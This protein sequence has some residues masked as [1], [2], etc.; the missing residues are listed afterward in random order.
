MSELPVT[1]FLVDDDP[2]V[3]ASLAWLLE[4]VKIATRTENSP[5]AF[6]QAIREVS[7][8]ACAVLDLRMSEMSGLELQ[9]RLTAEGLE[10]P[11]IFLTAHGDVPAAVNAMQAGAVDFLQKPFNP[12]VFLS[13]VN[14]MIRQ[15]RER[16]GEREEKARLARLLAKLS[17]READVLDALFDG[18]T[19]KEIGRLLEVSPKTVDVHRANI[20]RKLG[21]STGTGLTRMLVGLGYRRHRLPAL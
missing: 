15:A 7:G 19:S 13:G 18:L 5:L 16:F 20:M 12:Q 1:V 2:E 9:Q 6:L 3:T 8:P 11:L 17:R 21:V 4:S 14:R 10:I